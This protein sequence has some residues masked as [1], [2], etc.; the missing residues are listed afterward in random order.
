MVA[1]AHAPPARL[2]VSSRAHGAGRIAE[3]EGQLIKESLAVDQAAKA[4]YQED[5]AAAI[6]YATQFGEETG[7]ATLEAWRAFWMELFALTRDGFTITPPTQTQCVVG[8]SKT[9]CTSRAMPVATASGC[10]HARVRPSPH[11]AWRMD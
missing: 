4:M 6:E 1:A 7:A 2:I 11:H 9:G 8:G 10:T 5:P 3:L